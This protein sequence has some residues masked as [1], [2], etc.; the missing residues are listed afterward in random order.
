MPSCINP[1]VD[2]LL[3]FEPIISVYLDTQPTPSSIFTSTKTTLR[4]HY[5]AARTRAGLPALPSQQ[6]SDRDVLLYNSQ[7][8]LTE[9][10]ICNVAFWR[11]KWI[12]PPTSTGCLPGVVRR[13]LLEQGRI[14]EAEENVLTA[15]SVH[16]GDWILLMNGVIGCR[17]GKLIARP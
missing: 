6:S 5:E 11:S 7:Y 14:A 8:Q 1:D 16:E 10:S 2:D 15:D 13:W 3:R 4:G 9:S 17:I 12:T